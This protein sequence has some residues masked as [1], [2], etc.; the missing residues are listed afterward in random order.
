MEVI[1]TLITE[2]E[3]EERIEEL[4][5]EINS[6]YKDRK[7]IVICILKGAIY[8]YVDLT[9][10]LNMDPELDFMRVSSYSGEES[11][12]KINIKIDL[13]KDIKDRDI[14]IVEDIIDTGYTLKGLYEHLEK[15]EPNSIKLCCLLDK[16]ERRKVEGI[17]PDYTGFI[18]PNRFVIGYGLDRDESYRTLPRICCVTDEYDNKLESDR[19]KVQK[20][21]V[22][23]KS[24]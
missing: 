16:K 7:P 12:G 20:Q 11:T 6:D 24:I 4:A 8:F 22:K 10:K 18:I 23:R 2:E 14:L 21:L 17:N 3:L 15:K 9:R 5:E 19:E 13:D 1:K